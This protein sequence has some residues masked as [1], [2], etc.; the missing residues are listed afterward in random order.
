MRL[1]RK[2]LGLSQSKLADRVDSATN[3]IGMIETAKKFPSPE[4]IERIAEAL[5]I[6]TLQLFSM[7]PVQLDLSSIERLRKEI[8]SDIKKMLLKE[9]ASDAE[10]MVSDRLASDNI[11]ELVSTRLN[12]FREQAGIPS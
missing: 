2:N 4:M 5:Q 12:E 1:Y 11:A 10:R 3:Y 7:K 6:D 8:L 9:I